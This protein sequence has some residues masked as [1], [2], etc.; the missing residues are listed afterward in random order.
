MDFCA[1]EG[2]L[3]VLIVSLSLLGDKVDDFQFLF[4]LL[5]LMRVFVIGTTSASVGKSD[6]EELSLDLFLWL[7][8]FLSFSLYC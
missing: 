1:T 5:T 3:L 4:E 2:C 7:N 8:W 6:V